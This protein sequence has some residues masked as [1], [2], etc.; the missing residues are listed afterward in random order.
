MHASRWFCLETQAHGRS[1]ASSEMLSDTNQALQGVP[2]PAIGQDGQLDHK[3]RFQADW[4][5]MH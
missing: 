2:F 1:G 4:H 3:V 5:A